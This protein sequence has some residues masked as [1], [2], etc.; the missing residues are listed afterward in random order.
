[1]L[2]LEEVEGLRQVTIDLC[3]AAYPDL[4]PWLVRKECVSEESFKNSDKIGFLSNLYYY[5]LSMILHP[6]D[7]HDS[8][9]RNG[10]LVKVGWTSAT[11]SYRF[12]QQC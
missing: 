8:A 6:L 3:V 2:H 4:Q 9:R 1:M 11:V 5:Y 7:G 12:S 10:G